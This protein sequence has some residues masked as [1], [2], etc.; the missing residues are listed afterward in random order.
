MAERTAKEAF[1]ENIHKACDALDEI[2]QYLIAAAKIREP[3]WA[4]V[5]DMKRM[6]KCLHEA[7]NIEETDG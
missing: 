7:L 2:E 4:D 5:G 1:H 3:N 6:V